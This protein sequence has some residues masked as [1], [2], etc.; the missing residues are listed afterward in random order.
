MP[1]ANNN[2]GEMRVKIGFDM[3]LW[4]THVTEAHR[5]ILEDIKRTGYHGVEIPIFEGTP[6]Y[7]TGLGRLL[8]D[9]GLERTG[10]TV[11]GGLDQN[12]LSENPEDRKRGKEYLT[13]VLDCCAAM[14]A[15][16][17]GGPMHSTLGHFS[18]NPPTEAERERAREFH[19]E[20][21]DIAAAR[22][23]RLA[24]E[25]INRF[26]CYFA[27]TMDDLGRYVA[28]VGHPAIQA[29][30]DTFHANIEEA[31]PVGAFTRNA[32]H[33]IHVHIS[34][35][36]RGVPGRGHVPW[37]ATYKAIRDSGYDG[38]L[39][40]E[41]FG[42]SLPALGAATKIWR[43]LSEGPE[44]VYR[45]GYRNIREGWDAAGRKAT[46]A[47]PKRKAA[48][49]VKQPAATRKAAAV[50]KPAA[51]AP[52]RPKRPAAKKP[53]VSKRAK[54]APRRKPSAAIAA[55]RLAKPARRRTTP[56][57]P[58]RGGRPAKPKR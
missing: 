34:E 10:I 17:V 42:R 38:W 19:R 50:K 44:A 53:A 13:W 49:K 52:A 16:I 23:V 54:P 39:T 55:R 28:S 14:G 29:M 25:A 8:D 7:F 32:G 27:N 30:Y 9:V 41:A 21:G 2:R 18:G 24:L 57:R 46:P 43:D 11:I 58:A 37:A 1:L 35:N 56:Q 45:D 6:E 40:I 5:H 15:K 47:R 22:G 26:E 51:K 20:V 48:A 33:V 36:D 3:M 31:D 4:T 12:P